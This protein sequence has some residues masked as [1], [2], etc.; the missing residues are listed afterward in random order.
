MT[1]PIAT[2]PHSMPSSEGGLTTTEA[3]F[4]EQAQRNGELFIEQPYEMYSEE[5][6]ETWRR[7]YG[8]MADRWGSS[9]PR[10]GA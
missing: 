7:L 6:H 10:S 4:I 5:N 1:D 9:G 8:R 3:P 2:A